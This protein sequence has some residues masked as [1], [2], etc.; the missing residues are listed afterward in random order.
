MS[1]SKRRKS[2]QQEIW[3]PTHTL[4]ETPS[5]PFYTQL[6]RLLQEHG[7]DS[8][9]EELC[10]PYYAQRL[11]RPSIAPGVYFRM[12]MIGYFEG[13]GSE[14]A[15]AWRVADSLA[16]R[17]FLGYALTES[18]PDHS[19]LS[20]I[21]HRLPEAVHEAVFDW[22]LKVL[23]DHDLLQ[24]KTVAVD[25]TTL[26]ANA[27]MRS[28]VRRDT[29]QGYREYLEG[30][31]RAEGIPEP[32]RQEVARLD[33]KRANKASNRD[34]AHPH[35]R[36]ARITRMKDGRTHMAHK[37]EHTV[38][39]DTQA[40][41]ALQ[42]CG[43]DE[44]DTASLLWS[45]VQADRSLKEVGVDEQIRLSE[46]V[47]DRGYHSNA[48]M[49]MLRTAEIR[50]YVAEP[51]RG[52]RNWKKDAPAKEAVYANRRRIRGD[53]GKRL[54]RLRAEH[55]ER[56][57]AHTY[58]TGGMRRTHLRGHTNIYKRLCIHGGAFNLGLV[59]RK[60]TGKGTPKGLYGLAS[61][62]STFADRANALLG[63]IFGYLRLLSCPFRD[64]FYKW[65]CLA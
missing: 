23:S 8:F 39:L 13:L 53:R 11:G 60:L 55:V 58:E 33:R 38:D 20:R 7:F 22:V 44:G 3:V 2:Q 18:T 14:R 54:Q 50:S 6:N 30:L 51:D 61:V 25:A 9:V 21:R 15:I 26:E 29:G 32:T 10:A 46:V 49:K 24:G 27:A 28:I 59:M 48:T 57:F 62:F 35:D 4:P 42:V 5:H 43:A 65:E 12:L 1:M 36:E 64:H 17:R 16:L 47:A 45:L 52:R 37:A 34:W 31:A 40:L 56:S 41:V 19:S 63:R